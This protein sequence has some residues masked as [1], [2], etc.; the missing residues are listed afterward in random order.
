VTKGK[1]LPSRLRGWYVLAV[2]LRPEIGRFP[3][4]ADDLDRLAAMYAE[5]EALASELMRLRAAARDATTRLR[6]LART[7]D[8]LRTRMGAGLRSSLGFEADELIKY[9]FRPRR[10]EPG[11]D[12]VAA[13]R[14]K[15]AGAMPGAADETAGEFS[16]E[17]AAEP[18]GA[19][20]IELEPPA[21]E[22][23]DE[24]S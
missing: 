22:P 18:P 2:N 11:D 6:R 7:G 10:A 17:L 16:G 4:L 19:L 12:A 5:A 1:S 14:R 13:L 9:G 24:P 20:S 3:Q 15:D 21:G 23:F 8:M